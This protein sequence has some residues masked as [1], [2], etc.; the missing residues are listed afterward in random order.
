LRQRKEWLLQQNTEVSELNQQLLDTVNEYIQQLIKAAKNRIQQTPTYARNYLFER[1][2]SLAEETEAD[3][4]DT[5]LEALAFHL[6]SVLDSSSSRSKP[7]L[8]VSWAESGAARYAPLIRKIADM[9]ENDWN[10]S[11]PEEELALMGLFFSYEDPVPAKKRLILTVCLTGEGAAVSLEMWLK[12]Q[13]PAAYRDV[14]IRPLQIDP[15]TRQ[16]PRLSHWK[17]SYHLIAIVGTVPPVTDEVP[18]IPIWELYQPHGFERLLQLLE[19][20]QPHEPAQTEILF[21]RIPEWIEQG[22]RESVT[23]YN[24]KRFVRVLDE[25]APRFR[26]HFQWDAEREIGLWMHLGIYTDQILRQEREKKSGQPLEP[27]ASPEELPA[28]DIRLWEELL[29]R[30]SDT[31]FVVYPPQTSQEMARLSV[32]R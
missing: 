24:P 2:R 28:A 25:F 27:P 10:L 19:Q 17:E 3:I 16:S 6:Q 4:P 20:S 18:Y 12:E 22:L 29:S 21:E 31:F 14:E 1:L 9:V 32:T 5:R 26:S 8:P 13:L 23:H 30:L 7:P 15:L 11:L